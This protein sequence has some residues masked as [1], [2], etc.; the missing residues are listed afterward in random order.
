MRGMTTEDEQ[1]RDSYP[2]AGRDSGYV[3]DAGQPVGENIINRVTTLTTD[4][5]V[6]LNLLTT[7]VDA[8]IGK[9]DETAAKLDDAITH[10][11]RRFDYL[12]GQMQ[13]LIDTE[14][15]S[16]DV[17]A[18]EMR[19]NATEMSAAA[20]DMRAFTVQVKKNW[21]DITL[22]QAEKDAEIAA[23]GDRMTAI[24]HLP[25]VETAQALSRLERRLAEFE[26]TTNRHFQRFNVRQ[27]MQLIPIAVIVFIIAVAMLLSLAGGR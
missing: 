3:D 7:R 13:R 20:A 25:Q 27:W 23:I 10:Q 18:V 15:T 16:R 12:L 17:I 26:Q 4:N 5:Q 1:P 14:S 21:Q 6:R 2:N 8:T 9:V 19:T 11:E 22:W 24:E